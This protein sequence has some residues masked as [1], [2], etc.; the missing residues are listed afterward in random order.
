MVPTPSRRRAI[1]LVGAISKAGDVHRPA[2]PLPLGSVGYLLV[3][4]PEATGRSSE[5]V[6]RSEGPVAV[7]A[8]AS[9][10]VENWA[11]P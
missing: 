10:H 2:D 5:V 8:L 7:E 11:Q 6:I 9:A 4:T 3:A 1:H